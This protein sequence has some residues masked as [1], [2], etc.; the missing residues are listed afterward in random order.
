MARAKKVKAQSLMRGSVV[1]WK[2]KCG[3]ENCRCAKGKLHESWVLS[4]SVRGKTR[5]LSLREKDLPQVRAAL[6]RYKRELETLDERALK[7]I[8]KLRRTVEK[9]RER[10]GTG[11]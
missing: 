9:E 11:R 3:N 1:R 5:I 10:E 4:Y 8:E 2:R 6:S 7:G